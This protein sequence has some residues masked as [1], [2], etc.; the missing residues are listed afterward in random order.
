MENNIPQARSYTC[1]ELLTINVQLTT[2]YLTVVFPEYFNTTNLEGWA[3]RSLNV[4]LHEL[5]QVQNIVVGY[6]RC[7]KTSRLHAHAFLR[8]VRTVRI[9]RQIMD[10]QLQC[11]EG[12]V[13]HPYVVALRTV[14]DQ[15][16]V[17]KYVM[18][19]ETKIRGAVRGK[20][21]FVLD[22]DGYVEAL[23]NKKASVKRPSSREVFEEHEAEIRQG[24]YAR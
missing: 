10:M 16:R 4:F 18:K 12:R 9:T 13:L 20:D 15:I 8:F 23:L 7:P 24:D 19:E 21:I 22:K 17:I 6:E 1:E 3:M 11:M 5:P 14:D 2:W